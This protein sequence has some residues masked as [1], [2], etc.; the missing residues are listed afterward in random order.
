MELSHQLNLTLKEYIDLEQSTGQKHEFHNGEVFAL[1][2][3]S[4]EHALLIG[5]MYSGL[6]AALSQKESDCKPITNDAKLHIPKLNKYL[7]PDTMVFCGE[8]ERSATFQDALVN[9]TLI[10][11]VL[12]KS[13]SEYDRGDKFYFYR[14]IPTLREYVLVEQDRYVVEVYYKPTKKAL[15]NIMRYTGLEERIH[16][17][18]LEVNLSMNDLYYDINP[19]ATS[20][21]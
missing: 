21:V 15:W 6:R 2:G 13:T 1:A 11:E 10:V 17:Q 7:Y 4:L 14:Q 20:A 19:P 18:S 3:G 16:F 5:N 8:M 9:P 12:S